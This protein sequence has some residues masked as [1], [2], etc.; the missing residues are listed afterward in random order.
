MT[1]STKERVKMNNHIKTTVVDSKRRRILNNHYRVLER[2]IK[3]IYYNVKGQMA[4]NNL[5]KT[6]VGNLSCG[7]V[8][9]ARQP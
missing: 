6:A 7:R 3:M 2:V 8:T 4:K 5:I 1:W 9:T